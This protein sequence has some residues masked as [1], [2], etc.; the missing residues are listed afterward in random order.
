[1]VKNLVGF[2]SFITAASPAEPDV[3]DTPYNMSARRAVNG[4]APVPGRYILTVGKGLPPPIDNDLS[5]KVS[6]SKTPGGLFTTANLAVNPVLAANGDREYILD[7]AEATLLGALLVSD[8]AG[9][10]IRVDIERVNPRTTS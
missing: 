9:V 2:I 1:M 3:F 10:V 8:T 7:V 6:L 5:A 4:N